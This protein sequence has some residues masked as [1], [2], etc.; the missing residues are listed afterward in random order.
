MSLS[1]GLGLM[2]SDAVGGGGGLSR[3]DQ[4]ISG[5]VAE[6]DVTMPDSVDGTTIKNLTLSPADSSAQTAYDLTNNG[7]ALTGTAGTS[8]A[9]LLS[10]GN[11]FLRLAANPSFIQNLHNNSG[12][13]FTMVLAFKY[14]EDASNTM[15]FA[16]GRAITNEGIYLREVASVNAPQI[17]QTNGTTSGVVRSDPT[18][19][20]N[21]NNYVLIVSVSRSSNLVRFWLNSLTE[22]EQSLTFVST[23]NAI[24]A[25]LFT[26]GAETDGGNALGSGTEFRAAALTN[27][28][29]SDTEASAIFTAFNERHGDI[30]TIS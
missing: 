6:W 28:F 29:I 8:G 19:F 11:D 3:L 27:T 2:G 26:I 30:Y 23:T 9:Y 16:T 15:F 24:T 1:L 25:E 20:T 13:D 7:F 22:N 14:I 5:V 4:L 10:N 12:T 21:D 18:A 17:W